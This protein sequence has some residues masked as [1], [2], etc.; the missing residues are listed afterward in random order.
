MLYIKLHYVKT[1][2]IFIDFISPNYSF[3]ERGTKQINSA[4]IIKRLKDTD[5][6]YF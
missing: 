4:T 5:V 2:V 6:W 3:F 1:G